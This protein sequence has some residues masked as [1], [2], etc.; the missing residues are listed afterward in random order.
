MLVADGRL[1][2]LDED[3]E[4]SWTLTIPHGVRE[5]VARRLQHLSAEA[6]RVLAVASVI[7]REFELATLERVADLPDDPLLDALDEAVAARVI[8]E[9]PGAAGRYSF[10][11]GLVHEALHAELTATRRVRLHRRIAEA[12]ERLHRTRPE[13]H[14]AE[15]AHHFFEGLPGGDV[16]KAV[17]YARRAAERATAMLAYEQAA[18]QY[19][20][21]LDALRVAGDRRRR[22]SA[23]S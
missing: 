18:V 9:V 2:P 4:G 14:L 13:P 21:A 16:A 17:D 15:L 12:L 8:A 7:G 20:R 6:N 23:A 5:V 11:H 22:R 10:S 1:D 3:E 19:G